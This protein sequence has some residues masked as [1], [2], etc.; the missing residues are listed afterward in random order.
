MAKAI[1]KLYNDRKLGKELGKNGRN[2]V[3]KYLDRFNLT[4]QIHEELERIVHYV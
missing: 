1:L 4:K 3:E 2:Y